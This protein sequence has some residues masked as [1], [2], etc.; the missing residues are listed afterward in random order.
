MRKIVILGATSAIATATARLLAAQ[1]HELFLAARSAPALQALADDL[2]ARGAQRIETAH[3]DAE[4]TGTHA[5]LIESAAAVLG[6]L[7]T[8]IVAYGSLPDQGS[9]QD[10]PE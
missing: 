3:F 7:D 2:R 9:I 1:G 4:Q 5:A 10:D 6:G 8:A